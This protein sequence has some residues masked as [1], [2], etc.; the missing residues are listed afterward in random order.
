[1]QLRNIKNF[2][3]ENINFLFLDVNFSFLLILIINLVRRII[4]FLIKRFL[5]CKFGCIYIVNFRD[6]FILVIRK[7]LKQYILM[8]LERIGNGN[9]K[10]IIFKDFFFVE[11]IGE[12][13]MEV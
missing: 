5:E 2:I 12:V 13:L 9:I 4:E 8:N 1:M 6:E 10:R 3:I 7:V 11:N